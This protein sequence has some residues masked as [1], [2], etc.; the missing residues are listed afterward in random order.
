MK[1]LLII[2]LSVF[3]FSLVSCNDS[4]NQ[5]YAQN[6]PQSQPEINISTAVSTADGLDIKLVGALLQN[7]TCKNAEDLEKEINK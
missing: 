4:Q 2:V 3:A 5:S 7:G 6:E 1:N